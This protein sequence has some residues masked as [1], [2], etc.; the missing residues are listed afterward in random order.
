MS[1]LVM[2][3]ILFVC[4]DSTKVDTVANLFNDKLSQMWVI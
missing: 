4:F 2:N 1:V 3:L